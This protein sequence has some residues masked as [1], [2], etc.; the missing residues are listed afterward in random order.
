ME[1]TSRYTHLTLEERRIIL[2]GI[3]NGS[4]KATIAQIIGKDKSTIGKEIKAHRIL[5]KKCPLP[6]E[7]TAYRKCIYDRQCTLDCPGYMP[8]RCWRR[9]HSPGASNGCSE[10]SKC[11][12]DKYEYNPEKAQAVYRETLVDSRAGVN[13]TFTEAKTMADIIGPL[14]RQ[15]LSPYQILQTHP[16]LGI[17][18]KTL[19]N[20]IESEVF[21][22]MAG[23]TSMDLR[24]K[25]SRKPRKSA[26]TSYKKRQDRHYLQG[27]TYQDYRSYLAENP[28]AFVTQ[29]DTVYNDESSGPFIQTFKFVRAGL[30]FALLHEEKTASAILSGVCLLEE[31]LTPSLFRKYVHVLLTDRGSEFAAAQA[32]ET[33]SDGTRRTR[34]FF[35]DPMQ[36]GQKGTLENKHIELRYIL[37]KQTNLR[38]LG[39]TSQE[40]LNLVLSHVNS[41]PVKSLDGKSP[42]ELT[43]FLYPDLYEKLLDYGIRKIERDGIILKPYLL[44]TR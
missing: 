41:A 32:M 15:G 26:K 10:R 24:R 13:L 2:S 33:A 44:K 14:L 22:E 9:D 27:R 19:Y 4:T 29:M 11:R 31:I 34:V 42:M 5:V 12:F 25:V 8:F 16:E 23:I 43:A 36:S 18:E 40:D 39:L 7:C 37:P 1:K 38:E 35:C 3:T 30:I 6:L 20:Y 17:C 21:H 28:D